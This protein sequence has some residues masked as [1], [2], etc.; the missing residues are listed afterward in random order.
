[1]GYYLFLLLPLSV[2]GTD[3]L[4]I[5]DQVIE[6]QLLRLKNS[7]GEV[8]PA[9]TNIVAR[10]AAHPNYGVEGYRFEV[11]R[12]TEPTGCRLCFCR[13]VESNLCQC[14][15]SSC[16]VYI[17]EHKTKLIGRFYI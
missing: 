1:M 11:T 10:Q 16:L 5:P 9:L 6:S 14:F 2:E 4:S 13:I 12:L 7:F 3:M 17:N 8:M 15:L